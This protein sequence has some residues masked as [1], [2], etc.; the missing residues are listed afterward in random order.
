MTEIAE[1]A[2]VTR[3]SLYKSLSESGSPALATI[4][5]VM[6]QLGLKFSI[7]AIRPAIKGGRTYAS[8]TVSGHKRFRV[9]EPAPMDSVVKRAAGK[10]VTKGFAKKQA[11]RAEKKSA[12]AP[13]K[14]R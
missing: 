10:S 2:G 13:A 8:G 4:G 3:A 12:R 7:T 5:K 14:K 1:T 9:S 6:N 11:A